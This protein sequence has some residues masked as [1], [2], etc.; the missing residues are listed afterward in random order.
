MP[1]MER[2]CTLSQP[3][4]ADYAR[5][6]FPQQMRKCQPTDGYHQCP[7]RKD[8]HLLWDNEGPHAAVWLSERGNTV[9]L[10]PEA[11][12]ARQLQALLGASTCRVV[13]QHEPYGMWLG[14]TVSA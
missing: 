9:R 5:F 12:Y 3:V 10:L 8:E 13:R 6:R 1:T 4:V 2:I 14:D 7:L 11:G